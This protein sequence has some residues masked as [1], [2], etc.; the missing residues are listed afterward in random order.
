MRKKIISTAL[1]HHK[2]V[3]MAMKWSMKD[4]VSENIQHNYSWREWRRIKLNE[5][6]ILQK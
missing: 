6:V 2:N 3:G 5:Y 4:N 1:K